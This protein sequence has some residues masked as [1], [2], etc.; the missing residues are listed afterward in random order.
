VLGTLVQGS[1]DSGDANAEDTLDEVIG[2]TT[3]ELQV[4]ASKGED[5]DIY[6]EE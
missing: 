6:P 2:V 4:P 3:T 5:N 1:G